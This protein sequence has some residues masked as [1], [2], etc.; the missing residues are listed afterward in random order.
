MKKG[1]RFFGTNYAELK[2]GGTITASSA[3]TTKTFAFDGLP[4]TRWIT[5]GEGTDGNAISLEMDFGF[6]RTI[7]CL[8]VYNTNISDIVLSYWNGSSYTAINSGNATI[9]KDSTHQ[10]IFAK[11]NVSVD[12]Q[13]IKITGSN[14]ITANQ[15]KY[16]T[17]FMAFSELGQFQYFPEFEPQIEHKQNVFE[18]TDGR[19]VVIERGESFSAKISFKSHVNQDDITLVEALI[20]RREPFFIWPHGGDQDGIFRFSF[21]PFRFQDIIKVTIVGP[22]KPSFTKNYYRAGYNNVINI[23]EAV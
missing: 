18:T 20:V 23:V 5:N 3:D 13:K 14:T 2:F 21:R 7:D 11:L 22:S 12:T 8:Y 16:V 10:Y 4:G 9:I 1:L 17:Q 19:A 6:N 15:E